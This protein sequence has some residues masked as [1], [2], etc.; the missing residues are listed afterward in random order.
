M[1]LRSAISRLLPAVVLALAV[2]APA[3]ASNH[4][5]V[6]VLHASPDAPAVDIY[7]DDT[8]VSA[9]TNVPFTTLSEYLD[10]P[11]GDHNVKVYATGTTTDPVIDVDVTLAAGTAYTIAATDA[12][13]SITPQVLVDDPS[14]DCDTAQVRVVHFSA[15]A[16]AVDIAPAGATPDEAV[17]KNLAYADASEY[18]ALPGGTYDLEV[19]PA[20]DTAVALDLPGVAVEDCMA[21]SVFA[22]GSAA[23]PS[24]GG[25]GLQVVVGLDAS[26]DADMPETD[27]LP[28]ATGSNGVPPLALIGVAML[29]FAVSLRVLRT[30]VVAAGEPRD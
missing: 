18:V 29:A 16:P 19:R 23:D 2:A 10:V 26:A 5:T 15:D 22:I 9:L 28:A 24:V 1:S 25:N 12:V 17:I 4:A 21:Y 27:T 20:G 8:A 13:A 14:P 3:S 6:R 7:L 11:S 30:R